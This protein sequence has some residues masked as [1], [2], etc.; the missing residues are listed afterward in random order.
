MWKSDDAAVFL[1]GFIPS[2][3]IIVSIANNSKKRQAGFNTHGVLAKLGVTRKGSVTR[4]EDGYGMIKLKRTGVKRSLLDFDVA[5]A[6]RK[7]G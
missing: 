4:T 1:D 5:Q 2:I 7:R 6:M 3:E